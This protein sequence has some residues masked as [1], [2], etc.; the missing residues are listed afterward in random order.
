VTSVI[1]AAVIGAAVGTYIAYNA[2]VAEQAALFPALINQNAVAADEMLASNLALRNISRIVGRD[3]GNVISA[4][5]G[6]PLELG[7]V[8]ELGEARAT[9]RVRARARALEIQGQ[10]QAAAAARRAAMRREEVAREKIARGGFGGFVAGELIGAGLS[11]AVAR[12]TDSKRAGIA[13]FYAG[14]VAVPVFSM[15]PLGAGAGIGIAEY[16]RFSTY[17]GAAI[18]GGVSL[19]GSTFFAFDDIV[20]DE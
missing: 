14:A 4:H 11:T 13:V 16:L 19:I 1:V 17:S 10:E 8:E 3:P 18:G 15:I 6:V 9:V 2:V 5:T 12:V 20:S 7:T